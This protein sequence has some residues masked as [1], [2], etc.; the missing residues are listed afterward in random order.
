MTAS[1]KIGIV[2]IVIAAIMLIVG[3][4]MFS[5]QGANINPL[6]SKIGKYS[7]FLWL[8]FLIMGLIFLF[9]E[10]LTK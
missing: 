7:F 8:P 6:L 10:K 2:L 9:L 3:V 1:K 4:Y 5:Y